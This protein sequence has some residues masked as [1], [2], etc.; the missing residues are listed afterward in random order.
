[1]K[2]VNIEEVASHLAP[3]LPI[4]TSLPLLLHF[5]ALIYG[6]GSFASA[7][8]VIH[9]YVQK[10]TGNEGCRQF[11]LAVYEPAPFSEILQGLI[12]R[13]MLATLGLKSCRQNLWAGWFGV[14]LGID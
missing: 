2:F 7:K 5:P 6:A 14:C 3:F 8:F 12:S 1:M 9:D 13:L 10:M 11:S 4:Q